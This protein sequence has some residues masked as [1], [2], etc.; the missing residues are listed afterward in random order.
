MKK[1]PTLKE[2]NALPGLTISQLKEFAQ[3]YKLSLVPSLK[4]K[5]DLINWIHR[6][7]ESPSNIVIDY[8]IPGSV[9]SPKG[10]DQNVWDAMVKHAE[11]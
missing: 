11:R 5:Q 2:M 8:N 3:H 6:Y 9:K 7:L 1:Y 10:Y 4:K